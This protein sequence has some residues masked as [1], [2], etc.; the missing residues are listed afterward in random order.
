VRIATPN[1]IFYLSAESENLAESW[2]P[3][4]NSSVILDN[5]NQ[6]S[7]AIMTGWV[8]KKSKSTQKFTLKPRFLSIYKNSLYMFR[9]PDVI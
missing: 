8:L 9:T 4:I 6:I 1:R 5:S 2:I 7:D 3:I